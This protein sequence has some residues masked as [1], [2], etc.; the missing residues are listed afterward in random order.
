MAE[1]ELLY[2]RIKIAGLLSFIP[3]VLA[4]APLGGWFLGEFLQKRFNLSVYVT[5]TCIL[6][7]VAAGIR[8]VVKIIR[9]V[10]KID[11]HL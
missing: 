4:A 3:F 7:G 6:I 2:K 9:L 8:E 11:R 5:Y 1:K 10:I